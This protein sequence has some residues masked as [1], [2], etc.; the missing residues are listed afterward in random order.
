MNKYDDITAKYV[1][2]F[3]H[4]FCLLSMAGIHSRQIE[5]ALSDLHDD[6]F[7]MRQLVI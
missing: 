4:S 3:S 6:T 2:I 1:A 7:M 5:K